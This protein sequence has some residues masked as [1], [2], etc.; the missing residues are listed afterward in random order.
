MSPS[1]A[2]SSL[3]ILLGYFVLVIPF[4]DLVFRTPLLSKVQIPAFILDFMTR[5]TFLLTVLVSFYTVMVLLGVRYLLALPL[6]VYQKQRPRVA[7]ANSW[8]Q[9]SHGRWWPLI[10]RILVIGLV[11]SAVMIVFYGIIVGVQFLF[12]LLPGK[13][14]LVLA[15]MDLVLVQ[16]GSECLAIWI[17][18][19]TIQTLAHPLG[20]VLP[21]SSVSFTISRG[22]KRLLALV[23][24]LIIMVT[25]AGVSFYMA[26]TNDQ[27]VTIS[28]RGVVERNGVQNTIPAM[29]K[30]HRLHPDY[31]EMDIH[32]TKD[33][34]FV[35][36]HDENL[37][38]LAGV[39]KAPYQLTL[40]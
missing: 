19:L 13:L 9:T 23:A 2:A 18:I 3:L 5:N 11:A 38:E 33:H 24:G 6:M 35:V 16:L 4:A 17:G 27:P 10:A 34:Q 1:V 7:L 22:V 21:A 15:V 25:I 32:E 40:H 31:I 29:E 36:M 39:N 28:H 12:D 26:G 20:N 30:T 8:R 14:P 37:K